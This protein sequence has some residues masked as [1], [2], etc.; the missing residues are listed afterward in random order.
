MFDSFFTADIWQ[1][2]FLS[3]PLSSYAKT[4]AIFVGL[5]L[6]LKLLQ[7]LVLSRLKRISEKTQTKIDDLIIASIGSLRPPFYL[8]VSLWF[9]LQSLSLVPFLVAVINAILVIVVVYQVVISLQAPLDYVAK[10]SFPDPTRRQAFHLIVRIAKGV[11][12]GF[13][14]LL[15]LSNLG[16]NITSLVAGLGI[17]GIAVALAA[18]SILSDLFSSFSIYFDRPFEIGDFIVVGDVMGVVERIGVKTTRIR[19]LQ[20]EEIVL[21]NQ[22]LT[23]ARIQNFKK[24]QERRVV[25]SLGVTYDTPQK[26]LKRIPEMI[27][28]IV[29]EIEGARFDRAHFNQFGDSALLFEIVYFVESGEYNTYMNINQAIHLRIKEAFEKEKIEFAFPTRT[30]FLQK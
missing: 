9:A 25:V 1:R 5:L 27:S 4:V 26:S 29:G 24:M 11:L 22:E 23:S 13:A 10:H 2:T 12:W 18:Q 8:T 7:L 21:S 30:V 14:V 28:Q 17:G 19:S 6:I 15:I 16:I 3:N 20:G